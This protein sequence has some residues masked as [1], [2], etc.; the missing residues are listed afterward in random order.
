MSGACQIP[1]K[2]TG[3]HLG[4]RCRGLCCSGVCT[5]LLGITSRRKDWLAIGIVALTF[6]GANMS[7]EDSLV[8]W[9]TQIQL[10]LS[11]RM[12]MPHNKQPQSIQG[13]LRRIYSLVMLCVIRKV[14]VV[15]TQELKP[16]DKLLSQTLPVA[17]WGGNSE[18][19]VS[20]IMIR[21]GS[22][23]TQV[24]FTS[25]VRVVPGPLHPQ[26][27]NPTLS[28][29]LV[30]IANCLVGLEIQLS[31]TACAYHVWG[32][33]FNSQHHQKANYLRLSTGQRRE[34]NGAKS[35]RG[36]KAQERGVGSAQ[37]LVRASHHV[38]IQREGEK[39]IC[40][41]REGGQSYLIPLRANQA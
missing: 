24:T 33:E 9:H 5:G 29:F 30:A 16:M 41:I 31:V 13:D 17:V 20:Q 6:K 22:E 23:V 8:T 36:G 14:C 19:R 35:F 27:S 10:S 12:D 4:P 37:P 15:T 28:L 34:V 39:K 1:C 26:Q 32:P 3:S 40:S 2:P 18:S 38:T 21:S 11:L 25:M 7:E